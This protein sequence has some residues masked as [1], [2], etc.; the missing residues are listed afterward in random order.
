M[1]FKG[2]CVMQP[3]LC[4]H[5]PNLTSF[6]IVSYT[7]SL[8]FSF[9]CFPSAYNQNRPVNEFCVLTLQL[10]T[11]ALDREHHTDFTHQLCLTVDQDLTHFVT[12][13]Q[14]TVSAVRH[15]SGSTTFTP[16][17]SGASVSASTRVGRKVLSDLA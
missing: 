2:V 13:A 14:L 4:R 16:H 5:L 10:K 9:I 8:V 3:C 7:L 17:S 12:P 1:V 6:Y 11:T 15:G